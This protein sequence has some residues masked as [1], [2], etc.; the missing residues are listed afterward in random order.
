MCVF[1]ATYT[2]TR[3]DDHLI[4]QTAAAVQRERKWCSMRNYKCK[5]IIAY[6]YSNYTLRMACV[7][8]NKW[9]ASTHNR[10]SLDYYYHR[11]TA[12]KI[13]CNSQPVEFHIFFALADTHTRA[14]TDISF[15]MMFILE[16]FLHFEGKTVKFHKLMHKMRLTQ[17]LLDAHHWTVRT[18]LKNFNY[19]T[20]F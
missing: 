11:R 13:G 6:L 2:Q 12:L 1:F 17:L 10:R 19:S 3:D 4:I 8:I 16:T 9:S 5:R 20:I 18:I 15:A 14:T 7:C